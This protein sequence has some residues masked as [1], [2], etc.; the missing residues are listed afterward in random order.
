MRKGHK[1][2]EILHSEN[3]I[4][5]PQSSTAVLLAMIDWDSRLLK[6]LRK[7]SWIPCFEISTSSVK[8]PGTS[9]PSIVP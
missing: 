7:E 6:I 5:V 9:V 2:G 3:Q 1:K 8:E 4:K